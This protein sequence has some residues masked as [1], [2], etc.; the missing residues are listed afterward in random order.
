MTCMLFCLAV[1]VVKCDIFK[2]SSGNSRVS[3]FL[4]QSLNNWLFS[5]HSLCCSAGNGVS[6][7]LTHTHTPAV[8]RRQRDALEALFR[9]RYQ[10]VWLLER[11]E[12]LATQPSRRTVIS[13]YWSSIIRSMPVPGE[14]QTVNIM[15]FSNQW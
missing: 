11:C 4:I 13:A 9:F 2:D 10:E 14:L 8:A 7:D 12:S 6:D 1:P 15:H 5:V 3:I